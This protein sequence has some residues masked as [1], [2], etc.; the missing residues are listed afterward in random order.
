MTPLNTTRA[1]L[2][3]FLLISATGLAFAGPLTN[4]EL[5]A[6]R[7]AERIAE[8][9]ASPQNQPRRAERLDEAFQL[10]APIL[11]RP[12]P[13]ER[14]VWISLGRWAVAFND[15]AGGA[16]VLAGLRRDVPDFMTDETLGEIAANL[17]ANSRTRQLAP[18]ATA[19]LD[20]GDTPLAVIRHI[21]STL[22]WYHLAD[23]AGGMAFQTDPVAGSAAWSGLAAAFDNA[24]LADLS[25]TAKTR[26]EQR[27]SEIEDPARIARALIDAAE[28]QIRFNAVS[29]AVRNLTAAID[30]IQTLPA[31]PDRDRLTT[32]AARLMARAGKAEE[33]STVAASLAPDLADEVTLET[34]RFQAQRN[35]IPAAVQASARIRSHEITDL[36]SIAM[37]HALAKAGQTAEAES[38]AANITDPIAN[39]EAQAMILAHADDAT[40]DPS[41]WRRTLLNARPSEQRAMAMS[42]I[43]SVF[44]DRLP[45]SA[46]LQ[47]AMI[48]DGE[49]VDRTRRVEL[50]ERIFRENLT[51]GDDASNIHGKI[52][53]YAPSDT[54]YRL[55]LLFQAADIMKT[56]PKD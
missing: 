40:I 24:G 13:A 12:L 33:A 51:L 15:P 48:H 1:A 18:Q 20:A 29:N 16:V 31:G 4:E 56:N 28:G 45:P 49:T 32:D 39:A 47:V 14:Q 9:N 36:A 21:W 34:A 3:A 10:M 6:L 55:A 19:R 17:N 50:T 23:R 52:R 2:T 35:E 38:R 30:K 41:A 11:D 53:E 7:S 27:L 44:A 5:L 46:D 22:A 37:V 54:L 25:Q 43:I 42:R 8:L 26:A